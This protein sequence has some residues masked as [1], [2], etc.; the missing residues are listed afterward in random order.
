MQFVKFDLVEGLLLVI[1]NVV[2]GGSFQWWG[3]VPDWCEPAMKGMNQ[4]TSE[5]KN[6]SKSIQRKLLTENQTNEYYLQ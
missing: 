2:D 6:D 1:V 5:R 4:I 3:I